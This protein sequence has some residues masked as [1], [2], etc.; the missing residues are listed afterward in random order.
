MV[1]EALTETLIEVVLLFV[2]LLRV[3][4]SAKEVMEIV[5]LALDLLFIEISGSIPASL[6][7]CF[8]HQS[9]RVRFCPFTTLNHP[10]A[11]GFSLLLHKS[12]HITAF[13]EDVAIIILDILNL[14][15]TLHASFVKNL[16]LPRGELFT[17]Q[18]ALKFSLKKFFVDFLLSPDVLRCRLL[19]VLI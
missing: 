18:A 12:D 17:H 4:H 10:T 1:L 3:L 14:A 16:E 9:L 11:G 15:T 2:Q 8:L 5:E 13:K 7:D 19:L 6:L